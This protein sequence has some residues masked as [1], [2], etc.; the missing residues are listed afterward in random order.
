ML[1]PLAALIGFVKTNGIETIGS[2]NK[3]DRW[4][5]TAVF[6]NRYDQS[7]DT[8]SSSDFTSMKAWLLDDDKVPD[9]VQKF[10][11]DSVDLDT[12]DKQSSAIYRGVMNL[13][14]LSGALDF[15]TGQPPQFDKEKIQDDHIFPKSIYKE[16]SIAN[17]TLISTNVQKSNEK[18][19]DYFEKRVQE[20][21]EE[22]LKR[23]LRSHIIPEEALDYLLE[24]K[25]QEFMEVR[26]KAIIANLREKLGLGR[27]V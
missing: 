1:V 18:P 14:V 21:G 16:H 7:V 4:Y 22:E 9:F 25:L 6:S 23:I 24:D 3:I 27:K 10:D 2:Y 20:H 12:I 19:S 13:V 26:K 8:V 17:R 11:P 5:W 15:R